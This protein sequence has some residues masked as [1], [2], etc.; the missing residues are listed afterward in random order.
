MV[1]ATGSARAA[2][3]AAR[4]LT[5]AL[6]H[7]GRLV[8][9]TKSAVTT[10]ALQGLQ[11]LSVQV[12][13]A[14]QS[15]SF[16]EFTVRRIL[17]AAQGLANGPAVVPVRTVARRPCLSHLGGYRPRSSASYSRFGRSHRQQGAQKCSQSPG[18]PQELSLFSHHH[19][20]GACR[21][22]LVGRV[23]PLGQPPFRHWRRAVGGVRLGELAEAGPAISPSPALPEPA[24][25]WFFAAGSL[26]SPVAQRPH[27]LPV[28][29][30]RNEASRLPPQ[31]GNFWPTGRGMGPPPIDCFRC[32]ENRQ[33]SCFIQPEAEWVEAFAASWSGETDWLFPPV[34]ASS[35]STT[36][37]HVCTGP[38]RGTVIV[39]LA[40]W[41][42]WHSLLHLR[43]T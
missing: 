27:R 41:S 22:H 21:G 39:P 29:C 36:V 8:H 3:S 6:R 16:S 12:D 42:S 34:T 7:F 20:R 18:R 40:P 14:N 31:F 24:G 28:A 1:F 32:A 43:D 19:A 23:S 30:V 33:T 4:T 2:L 13:L 38:A 35:I 25:W 9:P 11:A 37:V 5:K 26:A 10:S 17:D 15:F